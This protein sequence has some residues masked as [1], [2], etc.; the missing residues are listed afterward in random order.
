MRG[1]SKERSRTTVKF[2]PEK[3]GEVYHFPKWGQM[4][5]EEAQKDGEQT[6]RARPQ[7]RQ[8]GGCHTSRGAP[9]RQRDTE[10][11][12]QGPAQERTWGPSASS[13]AEISSRVATDRAAP[14]GGSTI[15][16]HSA[17]ETAQEGE[18]GDLQVKVRKAPKEQR[19][20]R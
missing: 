9:S 15:R 16:G 20:G 14:E 4:Q 19:R 2:R 6:G 17:E 7:T 5:R 11:Q 18:R 10:V 3:E 8:P 1:D 12:G 13:P